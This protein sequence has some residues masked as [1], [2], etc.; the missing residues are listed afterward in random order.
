VIG[1]GDAYAALAEGAQMAVDGDA[2]R[3]QQAS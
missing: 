2:I 3:V 1:L